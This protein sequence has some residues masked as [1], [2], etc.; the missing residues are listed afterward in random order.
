MSVYRGK[1]GETVASPLITVV[2]DATL[3]QKYGS[4]QY[5]DEGQKAQRNVLIRNGV[6]EQY[7]YD[8]HT[9]W[10]EGTTSTANGRRE[11]YRVKPV[12]RMSNTMILPGKDK[13]ED[14][15]QSV[16]HGLLVTKMGGGQVNSITGDYVFDVAEG[17][18]IENGEISY[19]V[20][21]ATLAGNG[22]ESLRQVEM[23]ADDLGFAIGTC[24]K[25]GQSAP[26]SDAQPTMK[27]N[28]LVVGGTAADT[29]FTIQ[30]K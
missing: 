29:D 14:I 16:S 21:G 25:S 19:A 8:L 28:G 11:S 4:Y 2:D 30:R 22:P 26:V 24:G 15:I 1:L 12:T 5:D 27:I 7:M 6:L 9:A 3:A 23:V 18:L 13:K 20:K 17:Y 10:Q